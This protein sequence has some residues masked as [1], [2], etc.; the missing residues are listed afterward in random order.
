[1]RLRCSLGSG[2]VL[3][4]TAC[5]GSLT[6]EPGLGN[7]GSGG[8]GATVGHTGG[9]PSLGGAGGTNSMGGTGALCGLAAESAPPF[10]V[11]LRFA[12]NGSTPLWLWVECTLDFELTSCEDS[13][14]LGINPGCT[15][16]C[17]LSPMGC[18]DCGMCPAQSAL[19]SVGG[20]YDY[21]WNGQTYTFG[22]TPSGCSCHVPHDVPAGW[23]RVS[24]PV[25][26]TDPGMV[27][28]GPT[29]TIINDLPLYRA[30]DTVVVELLPP[31]DPP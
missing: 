28:T 25:W 5:G 29:Y 26:T 30:G 12:N 6:D 14:P 8:A 2:L 9:T 21:L 11:T 15:V 3:V 18:I 1:M 20:Y 17:A 7:V 10:S 31:P 23:Y 19:V 13:T 4:F 22:T 16:D 24:V 27:L